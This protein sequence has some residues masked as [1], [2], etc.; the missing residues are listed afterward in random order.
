[1]FRTKISEFNKFVQDL[2]KS[3]DPIEAI[4]AYLDSNK[5]VLGG[6]FTAV[7]EDNGQIS[8]VQ[9]S[10]M[11][12]TILKEILKDKPDSKYDD[13][14]IIVDSTIGSTYN[15]SVY[16]QDDV[17]MYRGEAK[18]ENGDW[19]ATLFA[20]TEKPDKSQNFEN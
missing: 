15:F 5:E 2:S 7:V 16:T 12:D 3:S 19:K 1:M 4:N 11:E 14:K 9:N 10:P 17:L 13:Y 20:P 18:I 6:R 8:I